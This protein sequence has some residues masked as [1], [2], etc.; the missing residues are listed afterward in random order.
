MRGGEPVAPE[1]WTAKTSPSGA[2]R[3]RVDFDALEMPAAMSIQLD[4]SVTDVNRQRGARTRASSSTR[5]TC[6]WA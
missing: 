1:T 6:T 2:H 5:R 3:F 4:A